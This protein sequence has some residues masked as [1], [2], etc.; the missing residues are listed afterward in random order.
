MI[1]VEVQ[2]EKDFM[3]RK[4]IRAGEK[5]AA[6]TERLYAVNENPMVATDKASPRVVPTDSD[7]NEAKHDGQAPVVAADAAASDVEKGVV[8]ESRRGSVKKEHFFYGGMGVQTDRNAVHLFTTE[9]WGY[10]QE[11]LKT[12]GLFTALKEANKRSLEIDRRFMHEDVLDV[13]LPPFFYTRTGCISR[14]AL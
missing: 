6:A 13:S 14:A 4:A 12:V 10:F 3:E 1:E 7:A 8:G 5:A 11:D 9:G 2:Q